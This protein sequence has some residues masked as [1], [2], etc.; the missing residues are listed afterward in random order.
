MLRDLI[1]LARPIQWIKNGVVLAALIFAGEVF[2]SQRVVNALLA[3]VVFCL[4]SSAVYVFNDLVDRTRDRAHRSKRIVPFG[5]S[6][7]HYRA[8]GSC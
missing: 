1:I 4:L 8:V 7:E 6:S 3:T 2:H 5:R